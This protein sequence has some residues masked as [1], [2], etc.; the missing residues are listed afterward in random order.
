MKELQVKRKG[1]KD[2]PLLTGIMQT[3]WGQFPI[4]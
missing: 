4:T 1:G 3:A 2:A